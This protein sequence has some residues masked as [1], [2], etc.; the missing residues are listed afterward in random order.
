MEATLEIDLPFDAASVVQVLEWGAHPEIAPFT[1]RQIVGWRDRF[2]CRYMDLEA[3]REIERL[4][5][6]LADVDKE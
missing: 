4:L 1:H 2:W 6:I 5:P 3:P